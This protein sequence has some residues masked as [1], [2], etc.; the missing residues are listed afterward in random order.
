MPGRFSHMVI[1]LGDEAQ[2]RAKGLW[3]LPA[4]APFHTEIRAGRHFIEAATPDV[5]LESAARV[6]HAMQRLLATM[7]MPFNYRLGLDPTGETTVCTGLAH[8]A[9]PAIDFTTRPAYGERMLFPDDI[10]AQAIRGEGLSVVRYMIGTEDGYSRLS[11]TNLM[12]NI[13]AFWGFGP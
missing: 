5:H 4:L 9:Y 2:L 6:F 13:A 11:E 8:L 12:Y 7:G 10:A 1:Y 3:H